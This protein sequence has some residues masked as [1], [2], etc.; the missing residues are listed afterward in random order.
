[1][2]EDKGADLSRRAVIASAA[3]IP[4]AAL[5]A[6]AQSTA[7]PPS[8]LSDAQLRL[9]AAFVDRISY[10][11]DQPIACRGDK[12]I[13]VGVF[14]DDRGHTYCTFSMPWSAS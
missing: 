5:T 9:V 2:P 3:I 7:A 1:M 10:R 12:C 8:A 11:V 6:A 4:V 13:G 14:L